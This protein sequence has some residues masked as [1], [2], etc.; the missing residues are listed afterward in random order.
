MRWICMRDSSGN[1]FFDSS[2]KKIGTHSPTLAQ[3]GA[4][5]SHLKLKEWLKRRSQSCQL[6][7]NRA[8]KVDNSLNSFSRLFVNILQTQFGKRFC[9]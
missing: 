2:S 1:P 9:F 3:L 7:G 6:S 4:C 5:P 8:I